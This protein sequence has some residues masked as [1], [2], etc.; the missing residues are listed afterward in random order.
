MAQGKVN[1]YV[2]PVYLI[3]IAKFF[4]TAGDDQHY[5]SEAG[6]NKREYKDGKLYSKYAW[7]DFLKKKY[8]TI[9]ALN[10]AWGSDYTTFDDDGGYGE[11]KGLLDE[12][13]R[14]EQWLGTD[15][16]GLRRQTGSAGRYGGFLY[17]FARHYA[18]TMVKAI[19]EVDHHHLI[20][21]PIALNSWGSRPRA[22]P[23]GTR[24]R[25]SGRYLREFRSRP[26]RFDRQQPDLRHFRQTRHRLVWHQCQ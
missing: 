6:N 9:A 3:A 17:E 13:G 4:Y 14:H 19:R 25:R 21:S 11:G 12:D 20:F 22:G 15:F 7:V 26:S 24:R 5:T 16:F 8:A 23:E 18:E 2:Q 10:S 1:K